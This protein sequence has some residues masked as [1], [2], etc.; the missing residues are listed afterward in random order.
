MSEVPS[1]GPTYAFGQNSVAIQRLVTQSELLNPFTQRLLEE[2]GLGLGMTVL[3]VGCGPGDV[4]LIAARLVGEAG[5][6]IGVDTNAAALQVAHARAQT[7]AVQQVTFIAGDIQN[8]GLEHEFDA[9][10]GRLILQHVSDP[11]DLLGLLAQRLRPGGLIAFQEYDLTGNSTVPPCPLWEQ[12]GD[13][14]REAMQRAG[15][16]LRMGMKLYS[17]FIAA[18]LP[19]PRLRY[20]AAVGAGPAWTGIDHLANTVRVLLPLIVRL[21]VATAEEV[22][23]DTLADRLREELVSHSSVARLSGIVAAWTRTGEPQAV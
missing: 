11:A 5:R 7:A 3:D 20:E 13:W 1:S 4:S 16:E 17:T 22:A 2:A 12:A 15:L 23:I 6:V 21:G 8:V 10:V 14:S 19:A 18:G 9:I